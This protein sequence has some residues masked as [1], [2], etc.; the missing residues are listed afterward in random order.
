M[1]NVI[2]NGNCCCH[3]INC[4]HSFLATN[5]VAVLLGRPFSNPHH[6]F[7][8]HRCPCRRRRPQSSGPCMSER[9]NLRGT[10][11]SIGEEGA[12]LV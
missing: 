4:F 3:N 7:Y 12:G 2:K 11:G 8:H 6:Y 9:I 5:V 10:D 1:L